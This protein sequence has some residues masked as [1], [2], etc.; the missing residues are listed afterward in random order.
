MLISK[1]GG[2]IFN[3]RK[4][5]AEE[6]ALELSCWDIPPSRECTGKPFSLENEQIRARVKS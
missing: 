4:K 5:T 2:F 3:H 1:T 6:R